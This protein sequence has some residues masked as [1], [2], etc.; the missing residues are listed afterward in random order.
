[1]V[2]PRYRNCLLPL[3]SLIPLARGSRLLRKLRYFALTLVS[4]PSYFTA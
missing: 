2:F 4:V 1:M 3:S